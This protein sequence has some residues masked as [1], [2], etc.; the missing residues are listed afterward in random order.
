MKVDSSMNAPSP[1]IASGEPNTSPTKPENADQFIPNWNSC[2]SPVAAPIAKLI[3]NSTPKKRVSRSH[4]S[5]RLRY[6][7]VCM[8]ASSGASP[9]VSGTKMKW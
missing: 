5:S 3:R 7:S 1:S 2:T 9:S 6:Q 8:I 4:F